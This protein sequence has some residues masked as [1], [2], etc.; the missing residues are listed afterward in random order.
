MLKQHYSYSNE[1]ISGQDDLCLNKLLYFLFYI[2][3][4][5]HNFNQF[6][7][8]DIIMLTLEASSKVIHI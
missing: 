5:N 4:T 8:N 2:E 6:C 7:N 3:E 1:I